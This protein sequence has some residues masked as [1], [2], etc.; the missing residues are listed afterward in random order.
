MAQHF[1]LITKRDHMN[2]MDSKFITYDERP[3]NVTV[4]ASTGDIIIWE[5]Q[6]LCR[7]EA[8]EDPLLE[9]EEALSTI[10]PS[11]WPKWRRRTYTVA[12]E[13]LSKLQLNGL[14]IPPP[15]SLGRI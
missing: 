4:L 12:W 14:P 7:V 1:A 9:E 8:I 5:A 10:W 2:T 13:L 11:T 15:R 6:T 3:P